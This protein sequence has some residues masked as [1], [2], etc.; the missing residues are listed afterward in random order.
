MKKVNLNLLKLILKIKTKTMKLNYISALL[1]FGT[2][3]GAYAQV[4]DKVVVV[5]SNYK[6]KVEQAEKVNIAPQFSD[7]S[8]VKPQI[9][10]SVL[11]SRIETNYNIKPIKPAKL[12]GSKLDEY[13]NSQVKLG[14]GN[15]T[16]PLVEF[17]IHNLRSKDYAVGAYAFHR[18]A[19]YKMNRDYAA[20]VPAGYSKNKASVYGKRFYRDV[21]LEGELYLNTN[22]YRYYGYNLELFPDTVLEAKD[23]RQYYTQVGVKAAVLSTHTDSTQLKYRLGVDANYFG[24][25]FKNKENSLIIPVNIRFPIKDFQVHF[26]AKYHYL[27]MKNDTSASIAKHTVLLNPQLTK[28]G[29]QWR[30]LLGLK[31]YI[32]TE[33]ESKVFLM[34]EATLTFDVIDK[35]LEA[36]FGL[37]GQLYTSNLSGVTQTNP[38]LSPGEKLRDKRNKIS[39]Y[40]GLRGRLSS[41]SGYLAEVSFNTY[42]NYHF[43]VNDSLSPLQN[44]F[45]VIYDDIEEVKFKGELWYSPFT[46][47]DFYLKGQYSN[48]KLALASKPWHVPKTKVS[49]TAQYNFKEKIFAGADLIYIGKRFA[50]DINLTD[51]EIAL[52][53][54]WDI[55]LKL[56]YKYSEVLSLFLD[57]HNIA[58][59]RYEIWNQYMSQGINVLG[60]FSY[61]F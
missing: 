16:T 12:V 11:P 49:F 2:I 17:D 36:Y 50:K 56:G 27:G 41:N 3:A 40:G 26:N 38:F 47:L 7:T 44:Q 35:A 58:A 46:Y 54:I 43:F 30:V 23:I 59:Q 25:D 1:F 19:H 45:T 10:Y 33:D 51:G 48:F 24:D 37:N 4:P 6:P 32:V 55:N 39:G 28:Q 13:Y 52:D 31:S 14:I 34:P 20:K 9:E 60:G 8:T 22:K 57:I 53:P 5:E 18:S 21:N 29:D 42:E 61:K 15:Y